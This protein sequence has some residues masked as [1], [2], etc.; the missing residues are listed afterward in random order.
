MRIWCQRKT[1]GFPVCLDRNVNGN[2]MNAGLSHRDKLPDP[3]G[4]HKQPM[5]W[6]ARQS[7]TGIGNH[8]GNIMNYVR[9][10]CLCM[11]P[12]FH[13]RTTFNE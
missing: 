13:T 2:S 3:D 1:L 8:M 9:P 5:R 7:D 4:A 11:E 12:L 10:A 6:F